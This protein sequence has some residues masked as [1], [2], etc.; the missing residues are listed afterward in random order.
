[1]IV[2]I[3]TT[4]LPLA[5]QIPMAY[6]YC[7]KYMEEQLITTLIQRRSI[8]FLYLAYMD[9]HSKE[10]E[11][12]AVQDSDDNRPGDTDIISERVDT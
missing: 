5:V 1:M 10:A 6:D 11:Q 4:I 7:D 9:E 2:N 8:A 3:L 12:D